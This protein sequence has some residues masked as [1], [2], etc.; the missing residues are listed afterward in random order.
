MVIHIPRAD[1]EKIVCVDDA[2]ESKQ[3]AVIRGFPMTN[4]FPQLT[5]GKNQRLVNF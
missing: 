2:P 4:K 1:A 3:H 5:E